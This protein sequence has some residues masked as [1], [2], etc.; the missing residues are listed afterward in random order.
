MIT[1][2][3][4][5]LLQDIILASDELGNHCVVDEQPVLDYFETNCTGELQ[6]GRRLLRL[7]PHE[8]W[9]MHNRILNDFPRTNNNLE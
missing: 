7:F 2:L 3:S 8:L 1:A 4:F 9:N 5:V 6:R